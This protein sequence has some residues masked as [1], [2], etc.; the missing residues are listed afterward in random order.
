MTLIY[1]HCCNTQSPGT[2]SRNLS[3]C[4]CF[5]VRGNAQRNESDASKWVNPAET[6]EEA[7]RYCLS[8][9]QT[10]AVTARRSLITQT[11]PA[12]TRVH[13]QQFGWQD[14]LM[15][16]KQHVMGSLSCLASDLPPAP[17]VAFYIE[18]FQPVIRWCTCVPWQLKKISGFLMQSNADSLSAGLVLVL[19]VTSA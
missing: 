13:Y 19:F 8:G 10:D 15:S 3:Q 14:Q 4:G 2:Y 18:M 11:Q 1:S 9:H 5:F 7:R 6:P 16:Q 12:H 17:T